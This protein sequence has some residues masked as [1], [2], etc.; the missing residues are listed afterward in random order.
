MLH[1][2]GKFSA[3]RPLVMFAFWFI[4]LGAAAVA[5]FSGFGHGALF[6]RLSSAMPEDPNSESAIANEWLAES[7]GGQTLIFRIDG[8]W[9]SQHQEIQDALEEHFEVIPVDY[10]ITSP[11]VPPAEYLEAIREA[12]PIEVE[13]AVRDG[14][15]NAITEAVKSQLPAG[16]PET[17]V[18]TAVD[19]ALA[20]QL[21]DQVKTVL[22]EAVET[23]LREALAEAEVNYLDD[24]PALR[25]LT[26]ET[27]AI[28]VVSTSEELQENTLKALDNASTF[29]DKLNVAVTWSTA[30]LIADQLSE[31]SAQDLKTG[32]LIS[33]PIALLVMLIIFGGF[34]AGSMP[35]IGG[36]AAIISGLATLWAF[37]FFMDIDTTVLSII[38]VI[39]LG[40]SID[41]GLLFI[42]RYREFLRS[43][44]PKNKD[45][46]AEVMGKTVNSAGRTIIFSSA[47]IAIAVGGLLAIPI[48]FMWSVAVS[49]ASVVLLASLAVVTL[50]PAILASVGL[51]ITKPSLISKLPGFGRITQAL[52]DVAPETG[53]FTKTTALIRKAP[54]LWL[55][56][57]I[58]VLVFFGSSIMSLKVASSGTPYLATEK[59]AYGFFQSLER[60]IP[61]FKQPTAKLVFEDADDFAKW[62]TVL[63]NHGESYTHADDSKVVTFEEANPL[64][65][66]E[67]RD[68]ENLPGLVTGVEAQDHDF[69]QA[70]LAGLPW[71]VLIIGVATFLLLFLLTGSL[72]VP[73][74][75]IFFSTLSLGASIGVLTWG[76]EGSG[77][78][79]IFGFEPGS[80]TAMSPIILVLAVVFGFGLAMDYSVFL[81]SRMKEDRDRLMAQAGSNLT[82]KE[83]NEIAR[84][85]VSTGLQATGRVITFAGLII[86]LVFLGFT[87][88][89][90][91]MIK[92][93]GVALAA[94][95]LVDMLLVRVVAVPATML[96]MGDAAWWAPKWLKKIQSIFEIKH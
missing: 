67:I 51:R 46:L 89:D 19:S 29:E 87:F 25:D 12:V 45:Q 69:N 47:T 15:T 26:T 18:N 88:G 78:A 66:R 75:A 37:S 62:E 54:T 20:T 49:A 57:S 1:W 44:Q 93:I 68:A 48:P 86:M 55:L 56:A 5:T 63:E 73:L 95:I 8:D 90:M 40:V 4:A 60:D 74:K 76:F 3:K 21:E 16:T 77:L 23:A 85:A 65:I 13:K 58:L 59:G 50:L 64:D 84:Q 52:G 14:V 53:L 9:R 79:G 28:V 39:G 71:A 34:I 35:L 42:S 61:T 43:E 17:M 27:S 33:L 38:T 92:Q 30:S 72:F 10:E 7:D 91:F 31:Q 81:M 6:D 80:I 2:L 11:L 24:I 41:Y 70:L 82:R 36:G 96:L 94:A 22:P 83:R 32:E